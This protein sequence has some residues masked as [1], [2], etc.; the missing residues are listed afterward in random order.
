MQPGA[1]IVDISIDQGGCFETSHV[2]T[3]AEPTYVVDGVV[4]YCVQH[5]RRRAAHLHLRAHQRDAAVRRSRSPTPGSRRRSRA[6]RRSPSGVNVYD[7]AIT[8]PGVAEAHG[9]DAVAARSVVAGA[10]A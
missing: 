2:T 9:L 8:N 4:H 7:G 3:H 5:A 6:T 10:R 1:V